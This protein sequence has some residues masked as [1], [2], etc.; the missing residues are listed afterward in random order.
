MHPQAQSF[1]EFV[2]TLFPDSFANVKVL[3]VGSGDIN[4]NNQS[5]FV[6]AD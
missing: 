1:M 5:L 4:G 6:N 3:D 2:K